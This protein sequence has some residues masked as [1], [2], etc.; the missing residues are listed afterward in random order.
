M[1]D[2]FG[3]PG[4]TLSYACLESIWGS[5]GGDYLILQIWWDLYGTTKQNEMEN[6][7]GHP[8]DLSNA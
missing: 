6:G 8:K 7:K 5:V 2:H 4:S 1:N 3:T